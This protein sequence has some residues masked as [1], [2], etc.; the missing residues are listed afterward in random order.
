M[1][2]HTRDKNNRVNLIAEAR[3]VRVLVLDRPPLLV[4]HIV[5]ESMFHIQLFRSSMI[6]VGVIFLWCCYFICTYQRYMPMIDIYRAY[7]QSMRCFVCVITRHAPVVV[8]GS[9]SRSRTERKPEQDLRHRLGHVIRTFRLKKLQRR[10]KNGG[11]ACLW[12]PFL[13]VE[14]SLWPL[15]FFVARVLPRVWIRISAG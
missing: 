6:L 11:D 13:L 1:D 4:F 12:V 10:T 2:N 7:I 9:C 3:T 8:A 14:A 15:L 5:H